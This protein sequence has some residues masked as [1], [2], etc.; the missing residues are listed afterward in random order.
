MAEGAA[1]PVLRHAA[2]AVVLDADDRV[3]LV[4]FRAEG[5]VW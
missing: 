1:E 4:R 5:S 2:R 3:L